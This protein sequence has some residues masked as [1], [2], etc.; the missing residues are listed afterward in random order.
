[1]EDKTIAWIVLLIAVTVI[2]VALIL[3]TYQYELEV[4]DNPLIQKSKMYLDCIYRCDSCD[5][6]F[7]ECVEA[8]NILP[9]S[10]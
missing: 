10:S 2:V 1:M 5:T 6:A 4:K 3:T 8:C 7:I 9:L